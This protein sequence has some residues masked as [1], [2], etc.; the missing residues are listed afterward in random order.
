MCDLQR[1][2]SS[3]EAKEMMSSGN[4]DLVILDIMGVDGYA[5]LELAKER[6]LLAVMLTA[7]A[8]TLDDTIRSYKKGAAFFV[9]KE[10]MVD[11]ESIL[12]D[13]LEAREKG[14]H[15]W[16]KLVGAHGRLL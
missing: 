8:M 12:V 5:L 16:Y 11:I 15:H 7:N 1:A 4:F 2:S 9:P 14:K 10:K 6:D 3:D 13:V